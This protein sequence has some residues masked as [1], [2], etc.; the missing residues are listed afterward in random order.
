MI[1]TMRTMTAAAPWLA[2][3]MMAVLALPC[4]ADTAYRWVDREG[5]VTY[6]DEPPPPDAQQ[7][8]EKP[9]QGGSLLP[10]AEDASADA[11]RQYPIVLYSVPACDACSAARAYLQERG[12][13]F[14][15]YN[16]NGNPELQ[17]KM[18]DKVG[19]LSVPTLTVGEKIM[20]GY[21]RS[22]LEGELDAA[23]YPRQPPEEEGT[24]GSAELPVPAPE[25]P[26]V[27]PEASET[28]AQ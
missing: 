27:P 11:A 15:E 14:T 3:A 18:K 17:K 19:E 2:T 24:E 5:N 28:S 6:Q 7:V 25:E 12:V 26:P 20:K 21:V 8:E 10:G 22:L 13:P 9:I 4:S 23:G 1:Q 16:V